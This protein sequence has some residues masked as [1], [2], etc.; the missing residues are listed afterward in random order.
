MLVVLKENKELIIKTDLFK[1]HHHYRCLPLTENDITEYMVYGVVFDQQ[2][3]DKYFESLNKRILRDF[4]SIGLLKDNG[5]PLSKT[6]FL[7]RAYVTKYGRGKN[8][9]YAFHFYVYPNE[10]MYRFSSLYSGPKV[11]QL[12]DVYE[13]Y[14][15][16]LDNNL[17]SLEC[18]LV[19]FGNCGVPLSNT[20]LRIRY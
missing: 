7:E 11:S 13:Y 16:I 4:K 20:S 8:R 18:G 10:C 14:L 6:A 12:K 2:G 15:Q 3:F 1:P 9:D 5:K 17:N 19:Q